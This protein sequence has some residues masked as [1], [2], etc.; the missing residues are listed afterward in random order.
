LF[1]TRKLLDFLNDFRCRHGSTLGEIEI[2]RKFNCVGATL[3]GWEA[4][5]KLVRELVT[6]LR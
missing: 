2:G 3:A 6:T 1:F 4:A 5:S